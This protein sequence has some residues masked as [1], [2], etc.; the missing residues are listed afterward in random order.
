MKCSTCGF[1]VLL[2]CLV[3]QQLQMKQIEQRNNKIF[4]MAT[5]A[6]VEINETRAL[7]NSIAF[8]VGK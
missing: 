3:V 1:W 8:E 4:D 5:K 2:V 6:L 7:A